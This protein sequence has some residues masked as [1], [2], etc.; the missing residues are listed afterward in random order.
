MSFTNGILTGR[1]RPTVAGLRRSGLLLV[2][3][4]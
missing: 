1:C 2:E 3:G 4:T